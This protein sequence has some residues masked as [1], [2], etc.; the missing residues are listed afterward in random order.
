MATRPEAIPAASATGEEREYIASQWK[1]IWWRFRRHRLAM[2]ASIVLIGF[3]LIVLFPE[4]L[5]IHSPI[6][7]NAPRAFTPPQRIHFL[8]GWKPVRP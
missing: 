1:L 2:A 7:D 6:Q 3:Y 8:D 4:F 5:S